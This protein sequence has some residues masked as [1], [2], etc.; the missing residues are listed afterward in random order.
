MKD[1]QS[2]EDEA[3]K[4]PVDAGRRRAALQVVTGML[5]AVPAVSIGGVALAE[6]FQR[7]RGRSNR[8]NRRCATDPRWCR[9]SSGK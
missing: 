7:S 9:P 3:L 4:L 8:R 6:E 5:L 1:T 2:T